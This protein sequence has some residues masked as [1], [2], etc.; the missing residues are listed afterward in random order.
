MTP[1]EKQ[2]RLKELSSDNIILSD[3]EIEEK[4]RLKDE[5]S[6]IHKEETEQFTNTNVSLGSGE[7]FTIPIKKQK[8]SLLD[9]I[10]KK[11]KKKPVT[12]EQIER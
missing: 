2:A 3:Q 1:E 9:I 6:L 8:R 10:I 7:A 12:F 11:L 5:L 4:E